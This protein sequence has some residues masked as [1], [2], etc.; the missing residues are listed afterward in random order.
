MLTSDAICDHGLIVFI[1]T[2]ME[3]DRKRAVKGTE[4]SQPL[5]RNGT[6][7]RDGK[8]ILTVIHTHTH[9]HT[10]TPVD[11][12]SVVDRVVEVHRETGQVHLFTNRSVVR[13]KAI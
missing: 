12:G 1:R 8:E 4:G 10:H 9:T 2:P 3:A 13:Y 7:W 6:R 11:H 5:R